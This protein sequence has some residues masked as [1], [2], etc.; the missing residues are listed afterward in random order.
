MIRNLKLGDVKQRITDPKKS[1]NEFVVST[2]DWE[3][4]YDFSAGK[5][6]F[7]N[8]FDEL[9]AACAAT[10]RHVEKRTAEDGGE[11]CGGFYRK[12]RVAR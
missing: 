3:F 6:Q 4:P 11:G 1:V 2:V 7:V 5:V 10:W 12:R 8:Y 9:K